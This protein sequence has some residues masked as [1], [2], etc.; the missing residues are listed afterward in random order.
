MNYLDIKWWGDRSKLPL[1]DFQEID[2]K[3]AQTSHYNANR[4][5]FDIQNPKT[6]NDK[7]QW[8]KFFDQQEDTIRCTD[9][10]LVKEFVKEKTNKD[11]YAKILWQSESTLDFPYEDLPEKF[12]L[13]TNNDSGTTFLVKD[14]KTFNFEQAFDKI[15]NTLNNVYGRI[16]GEWSYSKIKPMVFVEEYIED[17]KYELAS[18]YKF[19]CGKG[20]VFFCHYIYNRGKSTTTE[21]IIDI[22]GNQTNY[23]L[24]PNFQKGYGFSKPNNWNEM[25]EYA[26]ILSTQFKLVRADLYSSNNKIYVG[27]ITFW[28]YAGI[29]KGEDQKR[30]SELIPFDNTSFLDPIK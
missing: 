20:E 21:Q 10:I 22:S 7:I 12:V 1:K 8:T 6:L 14:K 19:F 3:N 23:Y 18:D 26:A 17:E 9:K 15:N 4:S 5:F 25:V 28:P 29:Y 16:Y 24:D 27:E 13:K 30:I 11:L 2:Y